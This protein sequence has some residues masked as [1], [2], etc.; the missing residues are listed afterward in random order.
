MASR[1]STRPADLDRLQAEGLA[2]DPAGD[3]QR[4]GDPDDAGQPQVGEQVRH[5]GQQALAQARVLLADRGRAHHAPG[6]RA[7]LAE[8]RDVRHDRLPAGAGAVGHPRA[9]GVAGV[10]GGERDAEPRGVAG[11]GDDDAVGVRDL[12]ERHARQALHAVRDRHRLEHPL[13]PGRRRQRLAQQ[14]AGGE[15]LGRR[16]DACALGPPEVDLGL[17]QRDPAD[18]D[19][20][21]GDDAELKSQEL[22]GDG[23]PPRHRG[24]PPSGTPDQNDLSTTFSTD[25][26][27]MAATV[28]WVVTLPSHRP[29]RQATKG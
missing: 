16:E 1:C 21:D 2:L 29:T 28:T 25:I 14:R 11:V 27:V 7:D 24:K 5:R 22:T 15:A 6:L 23:P 3:E 13:R 4:S 26:T 19:E 10:G 17:G 8:H 9:A 20:H 18:A 12:D